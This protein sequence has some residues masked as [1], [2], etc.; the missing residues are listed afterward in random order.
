MKYRKKGG[1]ELRAWFCV[2]ALKTIEYPVLYLKKRKRILLF[3]DFE[4]C[5]GVYFITFLAF[6]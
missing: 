1:D 5:E 3:D 2:R 4:F 6:C